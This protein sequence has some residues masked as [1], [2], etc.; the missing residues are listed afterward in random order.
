MRLVRGGFLNKETDKTVAIFADGE[1]E[2]VPLLAACNAK[3]TFIVQGE[4]RQHLWMSR[5]VR[6]ATPAQWRA[7]VARDRHCAFRGC[8]EP[9]KWCEAHHVEEYDRDHGPTDI[10]NLVLLCHHHHSLIHTNGWSAKMTPNQELHVTNPHGQVFCQHRH[11][12]PG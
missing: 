1:A 8:T 12:P 6:S 5:T 3:L 7:L 4:H 10:D 11:K 2:L 9:S